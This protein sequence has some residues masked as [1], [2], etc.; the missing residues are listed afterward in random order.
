MTLSCQNK[1]KR[2]N[3][4]CEVFSKSA[5]AGASAEIS[6]ATSEAACLQWLGTCWPLA[7]VP[8]TRFAKFSRRSQRTSTSR[9]NSPR[10]SSFTSCSA[11]ALPLASYT[12]W[13]TILAPCPRRTPNSMCSDQEKVVHLGELR[14]EPVQP[15]D[16]PWQDTLHAAVRRPFSTLVPDADHSQDIEQATMPLQQNAGPLGNKE[17]HPTGKP[18]VFLPGSPQ[19]TSGRGVSDPRWVGNLWFPWGAGDQGGEQHQHSLNSPGGDGKKATQNIIGERSG[20]L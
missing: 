14:H 16:E 3:A 6:N 1:L 18:L 19:E 2:G 20:E 7:R 5:M 17:D 9:V 11:N 15:L 13:Q 12:T 10:T 4:C 8:I